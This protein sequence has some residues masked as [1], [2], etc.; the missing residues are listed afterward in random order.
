MKVIYARCWSPE[1]AAREELLTE[2]ER[3]LVAQGVQGQ[4]LDLPPLDPASP[5][6]SLAAW[7]LL[8][9]DGMA[10]ALLCL[11]SSS[12]VLRHKRKCVWLLAGPG[13]LA[14]ENASFVEK[15]HAAGVNEAN[16][17]FAP[18]GVID[19]LASRGWQR[20]KL[21]DMPS[22]TS[23]EPGKAKKPLARLMKALR[24]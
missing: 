9:I 21:L 20:A 6:R 11:D 15:V 16:A 14:A 3:H 2:L 13:A 19:V 5:L 18:T 22:P 4:R 7:R 24:Q 23:R 8:P 17:I 12:S 1:W 10:D